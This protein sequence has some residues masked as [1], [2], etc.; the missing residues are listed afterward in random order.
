MERMQARTIAELM[1]LVARLELAPL[2]RPAA[3]PGDV[4][5][6]GLT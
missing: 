4:A 3:P 5:Q 6:D 1:H 2:A